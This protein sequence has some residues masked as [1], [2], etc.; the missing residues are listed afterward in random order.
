MLM[1]L[2]YLYL[3][4]K[5][6][7]LID[8]GEICI[9]DLNKW[10]NVNKLCLNIDKTCYSVFG[11]PDCDKASIKLKL[12]GLELQQVESTKYLGIIIDSHLTWEKHIDFLYKRIIKFT[13]IFYKIRNYLPNEVKKMIYFALIHSHLNYG[14]EIYGNCCQTY[15]NKLMVLNNE[16]LRI[17][18]NAPRDTKVVHLY[19]NFNT[20]TLPNLHKFNILLF[21]ISFFI[22]V[23]NYFKFFHHILQKK[24][25]FA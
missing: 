14:V 25:R 21:S 19:N 15:I 24:H 13:S 8:N 2:I 16:I 9:S 6:D 12:N 1:I 3:V 11:V 18:Q 23:I 5:V 22:I 20:L 4:K 7:D 10:F 17:L